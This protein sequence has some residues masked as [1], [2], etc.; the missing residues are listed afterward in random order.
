M[1]RTILVDGR[2]VEPGRM[3]L[4]AGGAGFGCDAR[5]RHHERDH[6][7]DV[8]HPD[9]IIE[10]VVVDDEA[11]M[12]SVL[13]D[14]EKIAESDVLLD[15]DDVG[16]RHHDVVDPPLAQAQNVLEHAALVRRET[17]FSSLPFEQH[18]EVGADRGRAPTEYRPQQPVR[19]RLRIFPGAVAGTARQ[20]HRVAG[21][22][23]GIL[24]SGHG[25]RTGGHHTR[26]QASC[27]A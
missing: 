21:V 27:G 8:H 17:C 13:E 20:R 15:R 25:G 24:V 16:P 5:L 7:A 23:L 2:K 9:R 22:G 10:G 18:L 26:F 6:V 4:A 1:V 3:R 14:L 11:R 19:P 12:G